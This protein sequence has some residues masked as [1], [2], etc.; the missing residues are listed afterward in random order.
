MKKLLLALSIA[1]VATTTVN[2]QSTEKAMPES[3]G[4]KQ[5][6]RSGML[7][8]QK[9]QLKEDLK[10]TDA[11]ATTVVKL[12]REMMPQMREV[13]QANIAT[14][15]KASKMKDL[16]DVLKTNLAREL[17]DEK[18]AEKVMQY[19]EAKMKQRMEKR[20]EAE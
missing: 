17:K 2:A 12:Q 3:G 7:E 15:E 18:L 11:Q 6:D 10:L 8:K 14:D 20:K 9:A 1:F 19:Q 5:F 13:M 16:R 4:G